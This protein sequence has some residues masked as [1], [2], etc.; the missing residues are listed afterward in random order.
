MVRKRR[1]CFLSRVGLSHHLSLPAVVKLYKSHHFYTP[2]EKEDRKS[3][4][5]SKVEIEEVGRREGG[6]F[7]VL[8]CLIYSTG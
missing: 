1:R 2:E 5:W 3:K 4:K 7:R 6:P 8:V